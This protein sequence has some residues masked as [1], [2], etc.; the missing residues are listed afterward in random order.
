MDFFEKGWDFVEE[1]VAARPHTVS[2]ALRRVPAVLRT[3]LEE[4]GA[5]SPGVI[6]S[7]TDGT[8][9]DLQKL[10]LDLLPNV[11]VADQ[12]TMEEGMLLL[13]EVAA[14]EAA[15]DRRR[16][17]YLDPGFIVQEVLV[18]TTA[19]RARVER[20]CVSEALREAD[21]A[22]KPAVRP[23]RFRLRGPGRVPG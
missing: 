11:A 10:I 14:P 20:A 1:P 2:E 6:R 9:S 18:R 17:E 12:A 8:P 7:L 21:V 22:W 3:A 19:K 5:T 13:Y 23:A 16:F 4:A 15:Q